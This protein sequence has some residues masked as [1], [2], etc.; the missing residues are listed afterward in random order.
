MA[1]IWRTHLLESY[2]R[3]CTCKV[4]IGLKRPLRTRTSKALYFYVAVAWGVVSLV[5]DVVRDGDDAPLCDKQKSR[6]GREKSEDKSRAVGPSMGYIRG[7]A[8]A[9]L[10]KSAQDGECW[11]V[12]RPRHTGGAR[13][14]IKPVPIGLRRLGQPGPDQ[15]S[16]CGENA[17]PLPHTHRCQDIPPVSRP[18]Q[19]RR[20]M[21]APASAQIRDRYLRAGHV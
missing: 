11:R 1:T 21:R 7:W 12:P 3:G 9:E 13:R 5:F 6:Q 18:H 14:W 2:D 8:C 15:I 16:D 17:Q 4:A 19:T 10:E 20:S